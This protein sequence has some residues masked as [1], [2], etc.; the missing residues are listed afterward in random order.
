MSVFLIVRDF[1]GGRSH[2]SESPQC[3]QSIFKALCPTSHASYSSLHSS[4]FYFDFTL[5]ILPY[6]LISSISALQDPIHFEFP[7]TFN[8]HFSEPLLSNSLLHRP[9][10]KVWKTNLLSSCFR[11]PWRTQ[12]ASSSISPCT[13]LGQG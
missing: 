13:F 12:N 6:L 9:L 2:T 3:S 10:S 4:D 11:I 8:F 7:G 5:F 1:P